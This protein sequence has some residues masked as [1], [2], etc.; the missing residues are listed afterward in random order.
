VRRWHAVGVAIS[1]VARGRSSN[2]TLGRGG[3]ILSVAG[4]VRSR[5]CPPR[6]PGLPCSRPWDS[7]RPSRVPWRMAGRL[8]VLVINPPAGAASTSPRSPRPPFPRDERAASPPPHP[9]PLLPPP[10]P[11]PHPCP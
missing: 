3:R 8:I 2:G 10:P 6:S 1:S 4:R 7:G 9:T 5:R 11:H